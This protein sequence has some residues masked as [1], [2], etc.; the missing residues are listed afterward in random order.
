[1]LV[2]ETVAD[3]SVVFFLSVY[4]VC[5]YTYTTIQLNYIKLNY[6]QNIH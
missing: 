6:I 1:M 2:L 3:F 5:K 4:D